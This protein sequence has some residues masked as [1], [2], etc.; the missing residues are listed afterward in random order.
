MTLIFEFFISI[1]GFALL[2][3]SMTRHHRDLFGMPPGK[4]RVRLFRWCGNI[5]LAVCVF[6]CVSGWGWT[7]GSSRALLI[8][9]SAGTI[10][11]FSLTYGQERISR[12]L[13]SL[14][15]HRSSK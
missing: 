9:A 3:L 6:S 14:S 12:A 1:V 10:V 13:K 11:V 8:M 4:K 7:V 5:A 2:S 15:N